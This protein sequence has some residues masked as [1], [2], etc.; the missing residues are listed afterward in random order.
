MSSPQDCQP[1]LCM[2]ILFLLVFLLIG[3]SWEVTSVWVWW[4]GLVDDIHVNLRLK[5]AGGVGL[6]DS[7]TSDLSTFPPTHSQLLP[8]LFSRRSQ[9]GWAR[10]KYVNKC[11]TL[12]SHRWIIPAGILT[13]LQMA[14][15]LYCPDCHFQRKSAQAILVDLCPLLHVMTPVEI[16]M[17]M[18]WIANLPQSPPSTEFWVNM[19]Y[20]CLEITACEI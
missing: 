2:V 17:N 18:L 16:I 11:N 10:I 15:P 13:Q 3:D 8:K 19:L 14:R 5:W 12:V 1:N 9:T 20:I 7:W 6:G 4:S